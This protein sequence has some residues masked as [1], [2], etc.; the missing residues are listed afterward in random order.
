MNSE[1]SNVIDVNESDLEKLSKA[2]LIKMVEK[3]QKPKIVI[4]DDDNGQVPQPQ[5]IPGQSTFQLEIQKLVDSLKS[6]QLNQN[7]QSN[8]PYQ[9]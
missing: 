1:I 4:V 6:I 2:E 7:H 5:K 3:L 8:P 9:D